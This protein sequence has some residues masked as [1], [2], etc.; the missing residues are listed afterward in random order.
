[1]EVGKSPRPVGPGK[2]LAVDVFVELGLEAAGG[3]EEFGEGEDWDEAGLDSLAIA[4]KCAARGCNGLYR[5]KAALADGK[6]FG[7]GGL[8]EP[9]DGRL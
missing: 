3:V 7:V 5:S 8:V 4:A 2:V 1:M 6:D 9:T